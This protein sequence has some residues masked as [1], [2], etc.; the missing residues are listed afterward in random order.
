[1]TMPY[2]F[3]LVMVNGLSIL[4][5]IKTDFTERKG[6]MSPLSRTT[7]SPGNEDV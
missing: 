2:P 6:L 3:L 1:M 4:R 7:S 5:A